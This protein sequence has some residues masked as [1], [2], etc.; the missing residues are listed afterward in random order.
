MVAQ[1]ENTSRLEAVQMKILQNVT[2]KQVLTER[3]KQEIADRYTR[4]KLQLQK[5]SEQLRF[6][7]KKVERM[8]KFHQDSLRREYEEEVQLRQEKIILLDFQ[9]DQLEMLPVGSE[10]QIS[11]CQAIVEIKE[12]DVWDEKVTQKVII[13]KD[14]IVKE[15]R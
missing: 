15:I 12:G 10:I 8:K 4:E 6:E 11:E 1:Q 3:G 14:G 9:K 13:V 2:V 5:E 7:L